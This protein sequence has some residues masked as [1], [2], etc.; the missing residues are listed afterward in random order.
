MAAADRQPDGAPP[1]A[2]GL[3]WGNENGG[4]RAFEL[5][6]QDVFEF[7][8]RSR[9]SEQPDMKMPRVT[10]QLLPV[11]SYSFSALVQQP[12]IFSFLDRN[13]NRFFAEKT[14][15]RSYIFPLSF[16]YID[17]RR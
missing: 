8:L 1:P 11:F 13:I 5:F 6:Y 14:V 10:G 17:E 16:R 2:A 15:E 7:S 9:R 3:V 12:S 4:S